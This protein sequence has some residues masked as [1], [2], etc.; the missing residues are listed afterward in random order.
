M[1]AVVEDKEFLAG[2]TGWR[3]SD[4]DDPRIE[5][6]WFQGRY[7]IVEGVLTLMPPAYFDASSRLMRLTTQ[8]Q[9]FCDANGI[10]GTFAAECDIIIAEARVVRADMIWM[11]PEQVARQREA[12]RLAKRESPERT[13]VLVP[14]TLIIESVSY[15]HEDHDRKTKFGWYAEFGVPNYWIFDPLQRSIDCFVLAEAGTYQL[16]AKGQGDDTVNV[17]LF[18]GLQLRLAELWQD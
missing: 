1:S 13:R 15:G 5:R 3:A 2:T 6:L 4:L 9:R 14:P 10:K 7:E 11:T 17:P 16:V 18:P 8:S 12:T